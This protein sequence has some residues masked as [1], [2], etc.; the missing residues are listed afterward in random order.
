MKTLTTKDLILIAMFAAMLTAASILVIPIGPVPITLQVFFFLLIPS[1]LGTIKGLITICIYLILGL[2]GLPVFAGGTGG[3]Q[4][5]LS[6]SFGYL[7]GSLAVAL[8]LGVT[9]KSSQ[10]YVLNLLHMIGSIFILYL[11]G[12]SYQ[13]FLMN[14]IL[15]T[16]L[17]LRA[18]LITNL[19]VF[20][21]IDLLKAVLACTVYRRLKRLV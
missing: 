17:S 6:P 9:I 15:N 20:F 12:I 18:I 19:S 1:L 21:P 7:I 4:A 3:L 11:F 10:S 5:V 13:Y 14:T 2:I 8:Y 16:P